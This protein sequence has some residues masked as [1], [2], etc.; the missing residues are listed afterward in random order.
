M[1]TLV[2][3]E[4][5]SILDSI[6]SAARRYREDTLYS[7]VLRFICSTGCRDVDILAYSKGPQRPLW[8]LSILCVKRG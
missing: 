3:T 2:A 6:R 4:D 8:D 7:A 1:C 5:N